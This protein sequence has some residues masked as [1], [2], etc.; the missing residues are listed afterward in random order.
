[1]KNTEEIDTSL[2]LQPIESGTTLPENFPAEGLFLLN[3]TLVLKD[4]VWDDY[5]NKELDQAQRLR[6]L[7]S[8]ISTIADAME[9]L[10]IELKRYPD[11]DDYT[12]GDNDQTWDEICGAMSA[13]FNVG[14]SGI[15]SLVDELRD[16]ATGDFM[17]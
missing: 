6:G 17:D 13:T 15:C 8:R 1:M 14:Y 3:L 10:G 9:Q 11:A 12:M 7:A 2:I 16:A 5:G 4:D